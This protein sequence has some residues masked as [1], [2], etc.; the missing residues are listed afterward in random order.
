MAFTRLA[1]TSTLMASQFV[2]LFS[3]RFSSFLVVFLAFLTSQFAARGKQQPDFEER[4][5]A[6]Q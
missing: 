6:S 1:I 5:A 3:L 2:I 4:K